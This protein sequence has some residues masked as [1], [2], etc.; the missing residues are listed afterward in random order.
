MVAKPSHFKVSQAYINNAEKSQVELNQDEAT[1][2]DTDHSNLRG[3]S[4]LTPI[5]LYMHKMNFDA[6]RVTNTSSLSDVSY[7]TKQ[8]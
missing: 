6:F 7:S 4:S 1:G 3:H 8:G 5:Y 2:S